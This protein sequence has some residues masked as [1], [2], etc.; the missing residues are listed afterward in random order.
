MSHF[1]LGRLIEFLSSRNPETIVKNGFGAGMSYRGYYDCLA[2]E[3]VKNTTYGQM[4]EHAMAA[5]NTTYQG[6]KGGDFTMT[7]DTLVYIAEYGCCGDEINELVL[8][9]GI[10]EGWKL[11]PSEMTDEIGEAIARNANCCGGIALDIYDAILNAAPAPE[12]D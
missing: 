7:G 10:P 12:D 5:M 8:S 1:N 2:F 4:L 6:Y 11:V 3:P 9:N